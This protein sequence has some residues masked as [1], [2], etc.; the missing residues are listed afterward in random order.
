MRVFAL[1]TREERGKEKGE[2]KG[3]GTVDHYASSFGRGSRPNSSNDILSN[4]DRKISGKDLLL[5]YLPEM[6][7]LTYS[8]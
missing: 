5:A 2:E 7:R 3:P 6:M 8:R 1:M 4:I